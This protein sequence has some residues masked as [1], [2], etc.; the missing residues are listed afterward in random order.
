MSE[1]R[2]TGKGA[3]TRMTKGVVGQHY[4]DLNTGNIYE[5]LVASE[6]SKLNGVIGGGYVWK[7]KYTGDDRRDHEAIFGAGNSVEKVL[8][9]QSVE[10]AKYP[11]MEGL[12]MAPPM[13]VAFQFVPGQAYKVEI[14]GES[15]DVVGKQITMDGQTG[16]TIGNALYIGVGD[17]T[18]EPFA[19]LT[20]T[21]DGAISMNIAIA[22]PA[23]N[24]AVNAVTSH[25]KITTMEE[26]SSGGG[27]KF[28]VTATFDLTYNHVT[29]DKTFD[30]TWAARISG[31]EVQLKFTDGINVDNYD[32]CE[33]E[34]VD[35]EPNK[36]KFAIPA[37][38]D[39][40]TSSLTGRTVEWSKRD[41]S[42][43]LYIGAFD[44]RGLNFFEMGTFYPAGI[45]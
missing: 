6:Q 28:V 10:F 34:K 21:N 40:S 31:Q 14:E 33:Y 3:P 23:T 39:K 41:N 7:L 4:E 36:L 22:T 24:D 42:L 37:I 2:L 32:V 29:W 18:G 12:Y 19:A 38:F 1:I 44:S 30:E 27:G 8:F 5:C 11:V 26:K 45:K 20:F 25:I 15:F 16:T 13:P 35:G 9:D 17:D 43:V